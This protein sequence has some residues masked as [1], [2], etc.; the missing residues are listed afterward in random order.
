MRV[1]ILIPAFR[2][3][4]LRQAVASALAQA[5]DDFELVISDDSGGEDVAAVVAQFR[6]PRLRY[7]RTA[8]RIGAG[9]NCRGLWAEARGDLLLFLLDD[10]VLMPHALA[11]LVALHAAHPQAAFY[12]GQRY[13]I[14]ASGRVT[15]SPDPLSKPVVVA[16]QSMIVANIAS[17]LVNPI[18]ELS[19]VLI[20]RRVGLT[21][22]DLLDYQGLEVHVNGDVVLFLNASRLGPGVGASLPIG[23]FRRHGDQNSSES[24]NPKFAIG[25][26]EWEVFIRGEWSR[27]RLSK[28]HALEGIDRLEKVYANWGPA[29]PAIADFGQGLTE[30]RRRI[31]ADDHDLLDTEFRR[32]WQAFV[33]RAQAEWRRARAASS[34]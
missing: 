20:N 4:F 12:W 17:R 13:I 27:R 1:S 33:E 22:D 32:R 26:C 31:D 34:D 21:I 6:D 16:D 9:A 11:E 29:Q 2:T 8:G 15:R 19:N 5:I 23:A 18:G 14:D 30:L 24:F 7:Y 10:D 3:T 25:I 28:A